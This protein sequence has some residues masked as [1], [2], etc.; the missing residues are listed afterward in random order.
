MSASNKGLK[1]LFTLSILLNVLLLGIGGGMAYQHFSHEPAEHIYR[2]MSPEAR[3]IVARTVQNAFREGRETMG[4]AREC[5]KNLRAI[6]AAENF[7]EDKFVAEAQRMQ[8]I[9]AE[10]GKKR[11]E[12]TLEL[13]KQ[14]S[15]EDRKVLAERFA[16]GFHDYDG[17]GKKDKHAHGFSKKQ[18]QGVNN[19][20]GRSKN[21]D[22]PE[23][24]PPQP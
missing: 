16:K 17:K 19:D 6:I 22:L 2:E 5:K 13:A 1:A 18:T 3:H 21:V 15:Q 11:I 9:K 20:A 7:D 8:S 12:V 10:M 23:D 14:L 24:M 4:E